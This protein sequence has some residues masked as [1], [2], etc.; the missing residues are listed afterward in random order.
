MLF[1]LRGSGRRTTVKVVYVTLAILM[2]G[3]L[4]FF[5]IGGDVNG[6]LFDAISGSSSGS[7]QDT[8]TFEKRAAAA[9]RKAAA[10]PQDAAAWAEAVRAQYQL[11]RAS[12]NVD[13][14]TGAYTATGLVALRKASADWEKHL[15]L[16]PKEPDDGVASIMVRA[17][18]TGLNDPVKAVTAQE[19]VA[20]ARPKS[21]TYG[22]LASLAYAAGQV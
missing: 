4:V 21:G 14:N 2:G 20:E 5:G 16:K 11:A 19:I 15:A 8:D 6:G 12:G 22:D 10:N 3:G 18:V 13:P 1:D 17:Y 7:S 9:Q